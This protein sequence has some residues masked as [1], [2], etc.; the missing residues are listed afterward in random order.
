MPLYWAQKVLCS[1]HWISEHENVART[2]IFLFFFSI[3]CV[4][5]NLQAFSQMRLSEASAH[6]GSFSDRIKEEPSQTQTNFAR[7]G[8]TGSSW[9]S[10]I[11]V[12]AADAMLSM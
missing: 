6:L 8:P 12:K 10:S 2:L 3:I 11:A 9:I 4:C 7:E 1:F 5:Y